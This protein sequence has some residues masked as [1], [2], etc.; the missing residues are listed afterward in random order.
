MADS[1][2]NTTL[3]GILFLIL[4]LAVF[5]LQDVIM[6]LFS[7][8]I[9]LQ[10]VIF[11]R[12]LVTI[13]IVS[14]LMFRAGGASSFATRRPVLCFLRGVAGFICFAT[15]SMA[16]AVLPLADAMPLYYTA[17]LFVIA[18]SVPF[19]GEKVGLRSWPSS[20]W[21]DSAAWHWAAAGWIT[22]IIPAPG[23]FCV[24]GAGRPCSSGA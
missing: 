10:E 4:G 12:G 22:S 11:L 5:S 21:A 2:E 15:F 13:A 17:P 3:K 1:T 14:A 7:S 20:R 19:L 24:P 18:L 9:A 6:K 8:R 16:L 23:I